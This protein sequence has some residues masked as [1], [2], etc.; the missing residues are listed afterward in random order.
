[1]PSPAIELTTEIERFRSKL[2]DLTLRN[3]LLNYRISKRKT[4]LLVDEIAD[5]VYRRLVDQEKT[6]QLI[7]DPTADEA[8][9]SKT[10]VDGDGRTVETNPIQPRF[11]FEAPPTPSPSR[12]I[13]KRSD[14]HLQSNLG[15][16]KFQATAKGIARDA[17]TTIEETG[18][19][20]LHLAM[21]FLKWHES[22]VSANGP[23]MAPLLLIPVSLHTTLSPSGG[24]E[25]KVAWNEDDVL[26]K[27]PW[28]WNGF[29]NQ[30]ET[31]WERQSPVVSRSSS[32][33][34]RMQI[35]F[36]SHR[37]QVAIDCSI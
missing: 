9:I 13:P 17:K 37:L 2:L 28:G 11:N 5:D 27:R 19:N 20:Y 25:F 6:M 34:R 7:P 10:P 36:I 33:E 12:R 21:G 29:W 1:M 26:T 16:I 8:L 15:P 3:P 24:Y 30:H 22:G 35:C 31:C 14:S 23:R 18:I 4:L 32:G